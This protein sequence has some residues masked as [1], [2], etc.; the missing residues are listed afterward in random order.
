[1]AQLKTILCIDDDADVLLVAQ[2]C[3]ETVGEFHVMAAKSGSE[4]LNMITRQLP[5]LILLDVMMPQ[6]DGPATLEMLRKNPLLDAV[7]IVFVTA[8]IRESEIAE[9]MRLG[10]NGVVAKPFDPIGLT[11]QVRTLWEQFHGR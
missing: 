11:A 2:M 5:D 3:L 9:Y 4:A 1:M 10:A 7:P 6:M 8:R